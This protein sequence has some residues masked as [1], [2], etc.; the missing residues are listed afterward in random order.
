[1]NSS[2][3]VAKKKVYRAPSLKTYGSLTEKTASTGNMG[4]NDNITKAKFHKTG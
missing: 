2:P 1:M 4:Q 3:E